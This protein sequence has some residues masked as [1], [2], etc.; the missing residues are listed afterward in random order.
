MHFFRWNIFYLLSYEQNILTNRIE[1]K[2]MNIKK[3]II[4]YDDVV[5]DDDDDVDDECDQYV[6]KKYLL[7][8]CE[9][10]LEFSIKLSVIGLI[11][12]T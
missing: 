8:V 6:K 1:G 9:V 2:L 11:W 3:I 5:D 4:F 10:G 12:K 7:R